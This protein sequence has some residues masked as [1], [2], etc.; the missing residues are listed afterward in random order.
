MLAITRRKGEPYQGPEKVPEAH[1]ESLMKAH[2][3][4]SHRRM[5]STSRSLTAKFLVVY[6]STVMATI[7]LLFGAIEYRRYQEQVNSLNRQLNEV[8]DL[9]RGPLTKAL[10]DFDT[11]V[12]ERMVEEMT[13]VPHLE[14]V[15]VYDPD[16]VAIA[17]AGAPRTLESVS[18]LST[19]R[20]LVYEHA[21]GKEPVGRLVVTFNGDEVRALLFERLLGDAA[22]MLVLAAILVGVTL[23]T[24]RRIIGAPLERLRH[25]IE[26]NRAE[27]FHEPVQWHSSDEL[28]QVVDAY[29]A[30]QQAQDEAESALRKARDELEDRVEARTAELNR[31]RAQVQ[32]ILD[33]SPAFIS[34]KDSESRYLMINRGMEELLGK[35]DAQVRGLTDRDFPEIYAAEQ[36]RRIEAQD[37]EAWSTGAALQFEEQVLVHG[38]PRSLMTFKFPL[39]DES[40]MPYALCAISTDITDRKQ[41]E[42]AIERARMLAEEASQAKSNF[43]ANMSHELRTPINAIQGFSRRLAQDRNTPGDHREKLSL[44]NRSGE[45]LL[46]VIND[47][48]DLSKIEA[49]REELRLE[50]FDLYAMLDEVAKLFELRAEGPGLRFALDIDPEL[51]K[52]IKADRGKLRDVLVNLLGNAMK[53][54]HQGVI[55]MRAGNRPVPGDP[56]MTRLRLEVEDSGAGISP[57]DRLRIFDAFYQAEK[58]RTASKGTG[59]GLAISKSYVEMMDGRIDVQSTL[60]KGSIFRVDVPVALAEAPEV[61]ERRSTGPAVLGL[62]SGQPAWRILVV[63]DNAD[64]RLLLSSLLREKGFEVREAENGEKAI[65][66]FQLWR[67]HLIW[68]DMRMPVMDGYRASARIRALAGGEAVKIVAITASAFDEQ[69]PDIL[70]VGCDEV[71]YKP[72]QDQEILDTMSRLLGVKYRYEVSD[73]PAGQAPA[74]GPTVVMLAGLPPEL[75]QD[76]SEAALV[77]DMEAIED[78]LRRIQAQA[79]E[80]ARHL[81]ALVQE[82]EMAR[83]RELLDEVGDLRV[84][85]KT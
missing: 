36:A 44:I 15:V 70:A 50:V 49:G 6:L 75:R 27:D 53:H 67:P 60:G 33:N 2:V 46:G 16:G 61:V 76:L 77:L 62:A 52:Y 35:P 84:G 45:N 78:V 13:R 30:L 80:T 18:E 25:S 21:G 26:R 65:A 79:P 3:P 85:L 51:P 31:S 63:E 48:L 24:T 12:I 1:T 23:I 37:Q 55:S 14:S 73:R 68:M 66:L 7:A 40:N 34:L 59:L 38:Q 19:A 41:A 82:Y 64:N 29:N 39:L 58:S 8:A 20:D 74:T 4:G 83:I 28:G 10:W 71:V 5:R 11:A 42:D 81:R 47:L 22:I 72:F 69:R 32:A 17:A 9:R 56:A 43:L 54:T 57:E